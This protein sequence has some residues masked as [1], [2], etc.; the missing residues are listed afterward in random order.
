MGSLGPGPHVMACGALAGA[1][2]FNRAHE[3]LGTLAHVM[4]DVANGR[5]AYA[6][7][8]HGGV[9]GLGEKFFAIPWEALA[10]DATRECFVLDVAREKLAA[11]MGFD[12][13]HWPSKA[14]PSPLQ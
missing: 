12:R 4:L 1:T 8:A 2:V 9:L 10:F 11:A 6:V 13:D 5:I 14:D 3:E 7:L